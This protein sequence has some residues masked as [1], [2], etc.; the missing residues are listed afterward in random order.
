MCNFYCIHCNEIVD[1]SIPSVIFKTG[2]YKQTV[3]LCICQSCSSFLNKSKSHPQ[4]TSSEYVKY[5]QK[6]GD[7]HE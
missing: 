1:D 6:Q 3:P 5:S 4:N 2:F 7:N